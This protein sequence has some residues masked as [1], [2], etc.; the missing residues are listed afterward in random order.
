M[1]IEI[2]Q[3]RPPPYPPP[4]A[5]EGKEGVPAFGRLIPLGVILTVMALAVVLGWHRQLS[6]ETLVRHHSAI[7]E[8][9]AAHR[10]V[11]ILSFIAVYSAAV[12]LSFPGA[13]LLTVAGGAIFGALTGGLAAAIAATLGA[14]SIF[15][16]TKYAFSCVAGCGWMRRA[17]P[18]AE[19]LAA[20]FRK[21]AFC[22]LVFLRLVPLF[23]FWLI[24]LISAPAG[25]ALVPFVTATALG[26]LPA[27]FA[28][29]FFGAG[30]NSAIVAQ[31]SAYQICVAAAGKADCRLNFDL[32]A[33][34]TPELIGGLVVL[35]LI[36]LIPPVARR[37]SA[38]RR[39]A[40][41]CPAPDPPPQ[42]GQG[43]ESR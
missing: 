5:G 10:V 39:R 40:K 23:P 42:A 24:N 32:Q 35:G 18:L 15:L 20:G 14:T 17:A 36:A 1:A 13:A 41:A 33:A 25:V 43:R 31:E 27:T 28:F 29:A 2:N 12:A 26:I 22:Y 30:L 11:A 37:C 8:S 4:H 19:K 38:M 34:V 21:D 16:I 9:V 7:E 6:F 3:A